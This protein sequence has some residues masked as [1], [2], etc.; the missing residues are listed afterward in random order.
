MTVTSLQE[1][2]REARLGRPNGT[3]GWFRRRKRRTQSAA[4]AVATAQAE[5]S[6]AS[7]QLLRDREMHKMRQERSAIVQPL[8]ELHQANHFAEIIRATLRGDGRN[9]GRT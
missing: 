8:A 7:A 4:L 6:L 9:H 5:A 3:M 1:T 2:L